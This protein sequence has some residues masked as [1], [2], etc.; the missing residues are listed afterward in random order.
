MKINRYTVYQK[1]SSND[2]NAKVRK[3]EVIGEYDDEKEAV[4]CAVRCAQRTRKDLMDYRD[5]AFST[6]VRYESEKVVYEV[7][8][9]SFEGLVEEFVVDVSIFYQE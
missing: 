6:R 2:I 8:K 7:F 1:L 4:D 9:N 5:P 3:A